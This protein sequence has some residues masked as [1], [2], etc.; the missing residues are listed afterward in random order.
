MKRLITY[1]LLLAMF[2]GIFSVGLLSIPGKAA[3]LPSATTSEIDSLFRA[4]SEGQHP[5][6]L[7]NASDFTRLRRLTQTDEY[8]RVW[9]ARI[10]DYCI[11][12]LDKPVCVY[13]LPDGQRLLDVSRVA[14][15]RII[16]M[17]MVYQLSGEERFAR[18][19]V[20]EMLAVSAFPDWHPS[21]FLDTSQM[22]YGVGIGYDWLYNYMTGAQRSVVGKALY[23]Y[24][25]QASP[26]NHWYHT[27]YNNWN[28][29]SHGGITVAACAIYEDYPTE[30]AAYLADAV[31]HLPYCLEVMAPSGAYP[32]GPGY[33]CIGMEFAVI[34]FEALR[35]VLGTDFG[36]SDIDGVRESGSFV[37]TVY[38]NVRSFNYGD[39]GDG[40]FPS[41]AM[42]HWYANRFHM[43]ELS[44]YQQ[45]GGTGDEVLS[46]L[47]YKPELMKDYSPENRQQ[48][49]F[50]LS[51]M[52]ESI[53]SFR[54]E[55]DTAIF[56]AIK[57]GDNQMSH[58]DL[59]IG[60]FVLEA[61]G[62]IW[63]EDLG[64]ENY[65]LP[66][67]WDKH[68]AAGRWQYYRKRAE[69]QNVIVINPDQYG[70]QVYNGK[71]QIGDYQS[72]YD[73]GYATMDLTDAYDG[74]GASSVRRG[75]MLFDNRSRVLLRDEITCT[76]PSEVYWFGHTKAQVTLSQDKKTAELMLNGKTLLAQ[77]ASPS[78][79]VFYVMDAQPLPT[80][81][82]PEGQNSRD[83]HR[84]LA[85]HL[86]NVK[87]TSIA[88]VFTPVMEDSDRTKSLPT[89][90]IADFSS[91]IHTANPS[92]TLQKNASGVYEIHTADQFCKF[93]EMVNS[94]TTFSGETV[95]LMSDLDLKGYTI[96]PVGGGDGTGIFRGTFDG[97]DHV[98]KSLFIYKPNSTYVGL[99]GYAQN[100]T[101]RNL[102]IDSGT[103]FC[104]EKSAAFLGYGV[105]VTLD[106][107]FN[108]AKV[109]CSTNHGGGIVGMLG[110]NSTIRNCYNHSIVSSK[111]SNSGGLVGY[112]TS[113]SVTTI[114]NCYHSGQLTDTQGRCGMI[115]FY[116]TSDPTYNIQKLIVENCRSTEP[117]KSPPV[118]DNTALETYIN[119]ETDSSA[120]LVGSA[121]SLGSSYIYDCEWENDGYPVFQWQCDTVLPSDLRL[122]N[123]AQ[124]RLLSYLVNSEKDNF[125]GKTIYLTQDIDLD[126]R[127]WVPIGG[128]MATDTYGPIFRGT[129][130]GLGHTVR[131]LRVSSD[132]NYM[133]FF[134]SVE[135]NIR[136][137][138]IQSGSVQGQLKIGG[139]AGYLKGSVSQCFNRATIQGSNC[140]GGL[141]GMS[142]AS[143]ITDSYNNA[144]VTSAS[145]VGG[146]VGYYSSASKGSA[147]ERSY[148]N[149]TLKGK[150]V[151]GIAGNIHTSITDIQF[152]NCY[153][154]D[155]VSTIGSYGGAVVENCQTISSS[156]LRN[157]DNVPGPQFHRDSLF[158]QNNGYPILNAFVYQGEP[159]PTLTPDA[160][161]IYNIYNEQ[162]L[163]A[164][165]YM[166]NEGGMTFEGKTVRLHADIDLEGRE[167]VPIGGNVP[168]EDMTIPTFNG[169]FD[170]G[171]YMISNL[172]ITTG[173]RYVGLF[174]SLYHAQ[175]S[176]IGVES[177]VIFGA[178]KIGG[179]AG[180]MRS[181]SSIT[182]CYNKA[183]VSGN[184]IS[185]GILGMLNGSDNLI[186]DC[187][188]TGDVGG[189]FT[190]NGQASS[191]GGIVGYYTSGCH[192]SK[193][194]NCYN[195]GGGS[196]GIIGVVNAAAKGNTLDNCR[197]MDTVPLVGTANALQ[198]SNCGSL[199]PPELRNASSAMGQ[200]F[201]E[202]YFTKNLLRP[203]LAWENGSHPT[204]LKTINGAYQ[205]YTPEDLRLVSYMVRKG[206]SF[207]SKTI[208]LRADLDLQ[209]KPWLPIGGADETTTY[210]FKGHFNG[211][212]YVIRNLNSVQWSPG[213]SGLFG[214][215]RG[216]KIESVGIESGFA[217]GKAYVAGIAGYIYSDTTVKN[218]YNR[219]FTYGDSISGGIVGMVGGAGCV[220]ENCYNTGRTCERTVTSSTGGLIGYLSSGVRS[221]QV[222]NC[223]NVGNTYGIICCLHAAATNV[224]I[225][226]CYSAQT[227][228]LVWQ[229]GSVVITDSKQLTSQKLKGYA[230]VLGSAFE[231]NSGTTNLGYPLL[232]WET[233]TLCYHEY[234][235][236][237][238][239]SAT[240]TT[241]CSRCGS[242]TKAAH[243][244]DGGT[245]ISTPTCTAAGSKKFTCTVCKEAKTDP[246]PANGHTESIDKAVS[247]TCTTPGKTEGKHCTVCNTVLV[248]QKTVAALGHSYS[249]KAT[250]NP[251]ISATG[252][253]TGTCSKCNGTTTV[254]LPKLNTTDY[255]KSTTKAPTCMETGIDSYKWKTTTYGTFAFTA[256]TN[257][258]GHSYVYSN[259]NVQGHLVTC[260]N[261]DLSVETSH[262]FTDGSCICGEAEIKEA[263]EDV[264][265]KLNHS[266]N[267]ASDIS[268]NLLIPKTLLEGFDMTTV[269]VESIVEIYEGN[270]KTGTTTIQIDPVDNGN[271]YYFTLDGLTAVQMNDKISSV[272][273]GT[274]NGQPY[275]SPVDEYSIASYAY[276][277]MNNP[278]RG[279]S[280]KI[281]CADLLR[282]G[283]KAQI[284]KAYR[285]NALADAN[286]TDAHK[287][288]L[289]D[290]EAVTFGN[291]NRVLNDME[292]APITW[293]G[294]SLNL[295]S[296]VALKFVFNPSGYEGDLSELS[297]RISY[298]G[299]GGNIKIL[300]LE[301]PEL[302][303]QAMG[304]YA[305]TLDTLLAAELRTIVSAQI[306]VGETP[307]SAT[308]QYSPDTYGNGKSGNLLDLCKALFAYSDSARAY[309]AP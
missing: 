270:E 124:L 283:A 114:S 121:V 154:T 58:S 56:A 138:G 131:N 109:V 66:G 120:K 203:V 180:N 153:T 259:V 67:Y 189:K 263:V 148:H 146:L 215:A 13:E 105:S 41:V 192:N 20:E 194:L 102:G 260:E 267:L 225:I 186:R 280:L 1:L 35:T 70:G 117:L 147:V 116:N 218:C 93:A 54:S 106:N 293:A 234:S 159:L 285:T 250:K 152:R 307:I 190:G 294:K 193:V 298:E 128:N 139:L 82:N 236:K 158:P 191:S 14:S 51:P 219:A 271:Y 163:R 133:G 49:H 309:F 297:L 308:L 50:L 100:A 134:G 7:A 136:N 86:S 220:V 290:I 52:Y 201:R 59:D 110:G 31:A 103:V 101:I 281:L 27:S 230:S 166:V 107:C 284:F 129:F 252:T 126:S 289:S 65:N 278:D 132:L 258:L 257:A 303:N 11:T 151:G 305:F 160:Q 241:S 265:L 135:G 24:G 246:I 125:S 108:R 19:A 223:Y 99:F 287:A 90:S 256:T 229:Y 53:A 231:A 269:Y 61:L 112:L 255:T 227:I 196:N 301:K 183:N 142:A 39:G 118:Q 33:Y 47:W 213:Y 9:Y 16:R 36:L 288:Y 208:E 247:P 177:G 37:F 69:G 75:F 6:I 242:A 299:I 221:L 306:Y 84:K 248:A 264:N 168:I 175:I 111:G 96:D 71:C 243:S 296:K 239:G 145:V 104:K 254:T 123:V 22:A 249:Y 182:E 302:Y 45:K 38:G 235:T 10:Y 60:T 171:G 141:V 261:C 29:W 277:Q 89:T 184:T 172:C 113:G 98:I 174:G 272:L 300:T 87:N 95:K 83:G 12:E 92:T 178:E 276:S 81:P 181:A 161:G 216:A 262:S 40:G 162:E 42:L 130:D 15:K 94:G 44:A 25:I 188:N 179:I 232:T 304:V 198:I 122:D 164:L 21:H 292:N 23:Q 4:R 233:G 226:N 251:T 275:Y 238:D 17:S 195:G 210:E 79:A 88:V 197:T 68:E 169:T 199:T 282:Y 137:F 80:S 240:H 211:R 85:I 32:E 279:E 156:Q 224:E 63:M 143:K 2:A 46:L 5:R 78:N 187:Y 127:E 157:I 119:C 237:S 8:M 149:G 73:G 245:T 140:V 206:N 3:A 212:G 74:Y 62:E 266:L 97:G 91:M 72:G 34:A 204:S 228:D 43:P 295:E 115:G 185:G 176:R 64:S 222:R 286:M 209:N 57:S 202:D 165:A 200:A 268:V 205:V 274:K 214:I 170:G 207:D 30:C 48:D 167:W 291:T 173:N 150:T 253:L 76:N 273:Y 28:S 144:S 55:D 217:M 77:I 155:G 18:R 244:W 26:T